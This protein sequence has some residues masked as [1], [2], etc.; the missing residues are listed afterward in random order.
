MLS[1]T[2]MFLRVITLRGER[3][4][5]SVHTDVEGSGVFFAMA[6]WWAERSRTVTAA[7]AWL[8]LGPQR[9]QNNVFPIWE[10]AERWELIPS[11]CSV[12]FPG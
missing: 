10:P 6:L 9:H 1:F 7:S 3:A 12:T 8:R 11:V 5:T 2:L 4:D